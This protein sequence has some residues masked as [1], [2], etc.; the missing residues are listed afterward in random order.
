MLVAINARYIHTNLAVRGITSCCKDA[1]LDVTFVETT[2]N[3]SIKSILSELHSED[4]NIYIF[5]CYIW[6]VHI[7]ERL[8]SDLRKIV[9][10]AYIG[11]GGPQVSFESRSYLEKNLDV[12]FVVCGEGEDVVPE[13]IRTLQNEGAIGF[14]KGLTIREGADIKEG[15]MAEKVKLDKLPFAYEDLNEVKDRIIYYESMRGC[16]F[17]CS[18]CLSGSD[19]EVRVKEISLVY[20]ELKR[21]LMA[22]VKQV[23]FVD[24]TFNSNKEH[25]MAIWR[26]LIE[27]DNGVT[28]FHFELSGELI[29]D[30]MIRILKQA[31]KGLLQFEI[32]VQSTNERTLNAIY[33]KSDF[34]ELSKRIEI[35][36]SLGNVEYHLDLISGLPYEDFQ[37]FAKSFNDVYELAP[38]QLHFG[39]L[40]ILSG[41]KIEQETIQ[42]EIVYS[43]YSP[44]EVLSTKWLSYKDIYTL[45]GIEGIVDIYYNSGRFVNILKYLLEHFN[46]PFSLYHALWLIYE[47]RGYDKASISGIAQYELLYD[48]MKAND[49]AV[50]DRAKF[51][52]KVDILNMEKLRKLPKWIDVDYTHAY[53][54]SIHEFLLDENMLAKYIPEYVGLRP[55][56]ITKTV[57]IEILPFDIDTGCEGVT[58]VIFDYKNKKVCRV[59]VNIGNMEIG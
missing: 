15:G 38:T 35:L 4:A 50:N 25:A 49:I 39:F 9:P 12:D 44:F 14:M 56:G 52:C 2:I 19:R 31:R 32:G 21:F 46:N 3:N 48:L 22:K 47:E 29:D 54:D 30:D 40:K 23:K 11:V 17:S 6:N 45:H 59:P 43:Q 1:G 27:N 42:H 53:G 8:V 41:S 26:Y 34:G 33:R 58:A 18:Y 13:V 16:P 57:H 51:G 55:Q 28:N 36:R 5:S 20:V 24:R 37:S 10:H 7:V